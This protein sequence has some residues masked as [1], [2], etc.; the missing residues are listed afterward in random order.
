[1][2]KILII[3]ISAGAGHTRAAEAI[4][5]TAEQKFPEFNVKHVD[6]FAYASRLAEIIFFAWYPIAARHMPSFYGFMYRFYSHKHPMR[7]ARFVTRWLGKLVA[8][9]LFRLIES[10]KPDYVIATHATPMHLL[11]SV[12][13]DLKNSFKTATVVTDYEAH[14]FWRIENN[15]QYFVA[16]KAVE[17]DLI[18]LGVPKT[19]INISGIP[20]DPV[21][22]KKKDINALREKYTISKEKECILILGG[23]YGFL[24]SADIVRPLLKSEKHRS[25][26][27]ITGKN[28]KQKRKLEML[29]SPAH[30]DLHIVEWTDVLD[31]YV[32]LSDIVI[33][34]PGALSLTECLAAKKR[35]VITPPIPGQERA[36]A[37]HM[38]TTHNIPIIKNLNAIESCISKSKQLFPE[39]FK[40][41]DGAHAILSH[42]KKELT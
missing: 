15:E 35:I 22:F 10:Y 17:E 7:L 2:K 39:T 18:R 31:E 26:I 9:P 5:R 19:K 40:V 3:S 11:S 38:N 21:W 1:M 23:G 41:P 28:K 6:F 29:H 30:I 37:L 20:I 25:I 34:K 4:K 36:N 24:K 16:I 14:T 33:T 12:K 32:G 13:N 8:K 27:V 42:I